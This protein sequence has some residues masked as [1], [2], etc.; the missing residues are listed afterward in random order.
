MC[1]PHK[2]MGV[3]IHSMLEKDR[4]DQP[5]INFP[6]AMGFGDRDCFAS[7]RGGEDILNVCKNNGSRINLFK[8]Q[9]GTHAFCI[10]YPEQTAESI[11]GHFEGTIADK[12]EPTI[13]GDY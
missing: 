4:M 13:F 3:V 9:K 6:V 12:W 2:L 5:E 7:S 1:I 11:I 8:F 10:E